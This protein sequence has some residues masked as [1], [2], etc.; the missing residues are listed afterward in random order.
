MLQREAVLEP[1]VCAIWFAEF[2]AIHPFR[3][4]NGRLGRLLN[5]MLLKKLGY[6]NAPL[7]PL[8]A[9]FYRTREKYYE[10]LAATNKGSNWQVWARYYCKELLK[11]YQQAAGMGDLRPVLD[12]Q[13]SKP[14]RAVL[15]WLLAGG[16]NW[17]RRSDYPNPDGYSDAAITA[18]LAS[19]HRQEVLDAKGEKKGRKYR[20][21]PQYLERIFAGVL[22]AGD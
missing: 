17:F 2:E 7:V 16:S 20:L 6:E 21:S 8:D 1:V 10:K 14:T 13:S 11:A 15:E 3:D 9:R 18:A 12:R 5:L 4:G 22:A 19:L